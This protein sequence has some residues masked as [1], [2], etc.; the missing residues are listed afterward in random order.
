MCFVFDKEKI[1][2]KLDESNVWHDEIDYS[3]DYSPELV[4]DSVEEVEERHKEVFFLKDA[5]WGYEQEFRVVSYSEDVTKLNI[6]DCLKWIVLMKNPDD[7]ALETGTIFNSAEYRALVSLCGN[8]KI[9]VAYGIFLRDESLVDS[10][11]DAPVW[12]RER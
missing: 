3:S 7:E 12:K 4:L 9:V 10:D 2:E 8:D 5:A 6:Y 1:I 11:G